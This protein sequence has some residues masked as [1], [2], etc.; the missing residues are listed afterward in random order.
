M[1]N[2]YLSWLLFIN[3]LQILMWK[4][5]IGLQLA[6]VIAQKVVNE[7]YIL[8]Q[9]WLSKQNIESKFNVQK[10]ISIRKSCLVQVPG[11]K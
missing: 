4:C 1:Q 6:T 8:F 2:I 9:K 10:H 3:N 5:E 11:S 7:R